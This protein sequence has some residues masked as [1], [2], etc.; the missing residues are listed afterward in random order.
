MKRSRK[1]TQHIIIKAYTKSKWD[2]VE[3]V[4]I[5]LSPEWIELTNRRL[6]AI[7][8]FKENAHLNYHSYWDAPVGYYSSPE[9]QDLL[10]K[11]L[12]KYEEWAFITLDPEEENTLPVPENVLD[13]Y[14]FMIT[15]DGIAHYKAYGKHTAEA[16][17]TV[18]FNLYR[19]ITKL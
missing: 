13:A 11:V 7:R 18:E 15:K 10:K 14:Q 8:E 17:W 9:G 4:I 16:F 3:F 19:V 2:N 6:A 1:P 5:H 12:P